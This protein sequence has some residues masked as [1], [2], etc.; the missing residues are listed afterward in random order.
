MCYRSMEG[1]IRIPAILARMPNRTANAVLAERTFLKFPKNSG[2]V[3]QMNRPLETDAIERLGRIANSTPGFPLADAPKRILV[4]HIVIPLHTTSTIS[5]HVCR[6]KRFQRGFGPTT[7]GGCLDSH[8]RFSAILR[9]VNYGC[10]NSGRCA[11]SSGTGWEC[12]RRERR[13]GKSIET[14]VHT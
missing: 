12:V 14:D 13:A 5:A 1:F 10:V 4:F 8:E 6:I 9:V 3:G 2:I 7:A 11:A